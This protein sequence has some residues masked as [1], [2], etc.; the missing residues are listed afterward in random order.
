METDIKKKEIKNWDTVTIILLI[1]SGLI[2]LFS[3]FAPYFFTKSAKNSDLDFTAT[4]AIG[5]TLGGIMN[6]FIALVGILLTFLAFYMQIKANQI[7]KQI[8]FDG[9][10][11]EKQ[12]E[13]DS[14]RKEH[15]TRLKVTKALL[16]SMIKYYKLSGNQL[17]D[18]SKLEKE[19]PLK[20]NTF[21]SSTSSSYQNFLKLDL[22]ETYKSLTFYFSDKDIDWEKDFVQV[23]DYLDFY[24]KM[25]LELRHTYQKHVSDKFLILSKNGEKLNSIMNNI[26]TNKELKDLE[27]NKI[28]L[29]LTRNEAD[30]K[31]LRENFL[32]P[33]I[34]KIYSL[35]DKY[36][37]KEYKIYL[38]DLS[39]VNKKIRGEELQSLNHADNFK[40]YY[41]SYFKE[42]NEF[43]K[44]IEDF[45]NLI[46]V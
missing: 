16:N 27:I 13:N 24:D 20:T 34:K 17:N 35:Y 46:V 38:D 18:Y 9:L 7:Q 6:P 10:E 11:I 32:I 3:F 21:N 31:L 44:K 37:Y 30:F 15:L 14:E 36:E 8:F 28:Y 25:I 40:S 19:Q 5:D 1:L 26:F 41:D 39:E 45:N 12:K 22:L 42:D 2:I 4:G 43:I 23:L 33:L 29:E